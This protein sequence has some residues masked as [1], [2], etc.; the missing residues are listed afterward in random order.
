MIVED[1]LGLLRIIQGAPEITA[2]PALTFPC[3]RAP[4]RATSLTCPLPGA[5]ENE[6]VSLVTVS[7]MC[8]VSL[9]MRCS[10]FLVLRSLLLF[11][12][13]VAYVSIKYTHVG[14]FGR[15]F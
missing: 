3:L 10:M 11:V 14:C 8:C 13:A 4:E 12:F 6:S 5:T 1:H 15:V 2:P 7:I 9:L